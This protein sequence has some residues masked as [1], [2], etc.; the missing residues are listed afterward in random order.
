MLYLDFCSVFPQEASAISFRKQIAASL[1]QHNA[2]VENIEQAQQ[3][4]SPVSC[5][6]SM[7]VF[8]NV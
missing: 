3:P 5:S 6:S 8:L 2:R 1:A 4:L 7:E